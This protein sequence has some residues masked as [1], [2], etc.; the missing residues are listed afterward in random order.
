MPSSST[1]ST[2]LERRIRW[3]FSRTHAHL[4]SACQHHI[5]GV[6]LPRFAEVLDIDQHRLLATV[7]PM[8]HGGSS[9]TIQEL[10]QL[11]FMFDEAD[12]LEDRDKIWNAGGFLEDVG[13][14]LEMVGRKAEAHQWSLWGLELRSVAVGML[15]KEKE[16]EERMKED[17]KMMT[18]GVR[19]RETHHSRGR[20][21]A[22]E[23]SDSE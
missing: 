16:E 7:K 6:F 3:L 1:R 21:G 14:A 13:Y 2:Y 5:I 12:R 10:G 23:W 4:T 9:V 17:E 8:H 15:L 18:Q 22:V 11:R 20:F 19:V